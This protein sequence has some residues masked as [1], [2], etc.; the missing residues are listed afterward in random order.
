MIGGNITIEEGHNYIDQGATATDNYDYDITDK[1]VK[2]GNVNPNVVGTY[3]ITYNVKD[4]NGN[5]AIA[6]IR[7]VF[8]VDK[9]IPLISLNGDATVSTEVGDPYTDLGATAVDNYDG[10]ISNKIVIEGIVDTSIIGEYTITYN[11]VDSEGNQALE[12]VRKVFVVDN[13]T[14]T[15]LFETNGNN[16]TYESNS[17]SIVLVTDAGGI[18]NESLKYLWSTSADEPDENSFIKSFTNGDLIKS[19]NNIDG[20]YYLW[21]LAKDETGNTKIAR[22]EAYYLDDINPKVT[23]TI[24]RTSKLIGNDIRYATIGEKVYVKLYFSE[25]LETYPIVTIGG[26]SISEYVIGTEASGR[27][28]YTYSTIITEEMANNLVEGEKI[29]FAYSTFKDIAGNEGVGAS[30]NTAGNGDY[31]IFDKTIPTGE[32]TFNPTGFTNEEVTATLTVSEPV[33]NITG[34]DKVSRTVFTKKYIEHTTSTVTAN[35]KDL[36]GNS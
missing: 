7:R 36:A 9:E 26:V 16:A 5:D 35:L 23:T 33:M 19:P 25:E 6:V 11:V 15:I 22:S 3:A 10:D 17:G 8:V 21:I 28:Y 31:V 13:K 27:K 24:F 18:N 29:P 32:V 12:V 1:I 2:T 34:W 30:L 14:P 4:T 20:I